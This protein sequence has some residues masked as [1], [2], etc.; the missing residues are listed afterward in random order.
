MVWLVCLHQGPAPAG[1]QVS[2]WWSEVVAGG[3]KEVAHSARQPLHGVVVALRVYGTA[4]RR[5]AQLVVRA[6]IIADKPAAAV[7]P[8][9]AQASSLGHAAGA[10]ASTAQYS[11]STT[12]SP[13]AGGS[14]PF[15][16][17]LN[18]PEVPIKWH[19]RLWQL[20][21]PYE[22]QQLLLDQA[23][24]EGNSMVAV[25]KGFGFSDAY[26]TASGDAVKAVFAGE[27]GSDPIVH[28]SRIPSFGEAV[29]TV[30]KESR[31][32]TG[33]SEG[34][35]LREGAL[36]GGVDGLRSLRL[37]AVSLTQQAAG[38]PA[39]FVMSWLHQW[40]LHHPHHH[41]FPVVLPAHPPTPPPPPPP[42]STVKLMGTDSLIQ[43]ADTRHRY[44]RGLLAPAFTP[45]AVASYLPQIVE[46]MQR[47]L[48]EW[49]DAGEEGV[50]GLDAFKLLTFEFIVGVSSGVEWC[51]AVE[52]LCW[53]VELVV[54]IDSQMGFEAHKEGSYM[55]SSQLTTTFS[56]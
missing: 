32:A 49:A 42:S 52:L 13:A 35:R 14:C 17:A 41:L 50:K 40:A 3:V 21:K 43:A 5:R 9:H 10:E 19:Q 26:M 23:V 33:G 45:E 22:F 16:N 11:D 29:R 39:A 34:Q 7:Q 2:G 6:Q 37:A 54:L 12:P 18:P 25:S 44:L 27:A 53:E 31:R 4:G 8:D 15:L 30:A 55:T 47:H 28:Q 36:T 51:A 24:Q 20:T 46:L 38:V 48:G 1:Q 56:H